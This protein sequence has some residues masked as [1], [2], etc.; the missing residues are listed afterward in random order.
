VTWPFL[1]ALV[2]N[3]TGILIGGF[4]QNVLTPGWS[5][6]QSMIWMSRLPEKNKMTATAVYN[7]AMNVGAFIMPLIG[8]AVSEA[9]GIRNTLLIG[10]AMNVLGGLMFY[11]RPV[12]SRVEEAEATPQ[13]V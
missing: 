1:V 4:V 5:L 3:L 12:T 9:I 7:T 13:G 10:G 8:V 11:I 2:P 6:S